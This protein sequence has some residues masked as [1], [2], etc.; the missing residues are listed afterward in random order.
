MIGV[1]LGLRKPLPSVGRGTKSS[2]EAALPTV[3]FIRLAMPSGTVRLRPDAKSV[4]AVDDPQVDLIGVRKVFGDSRHR[5][6]AVEGA[7]LEP[8]SAD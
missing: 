4:A 7:D 6:V 1:P 8:R 2:I 3:D 5:V